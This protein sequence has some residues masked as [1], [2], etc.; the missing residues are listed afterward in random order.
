MYKFFFQVDLWS[1]GILLYV[2]FCG[3]L[4]FDDDKILL[5]YKKIQV[6]LKI[7]FLIIYI[8]YLY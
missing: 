6:I 8:I 3:Y 4:F 7:Y 5:L 2:L 1:M